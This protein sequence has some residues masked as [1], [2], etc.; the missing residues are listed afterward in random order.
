LVVVDDDGG[1]YR[2]ETAWIICLYALE[3]YREWALRLA[4]PALRPLA[5]A[6]CHWFSRNRRSISRRLGLLPDDR[7][8]AVLRPLRPNACSIDSGGRPEEGSAP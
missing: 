5:R 8:E 7:L 4:S 6:A 3:G 1:V 2:G